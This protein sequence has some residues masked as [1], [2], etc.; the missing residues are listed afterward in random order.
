MSY[1]SLIFSL[2]V[3]LMFCPVLTNAQQLSPIDY[4]TNTP[5]DT[6]N[7][8]A[9]ILV[10]AD[11][12]TP[13]L[14]RGRPEP[15]ANNPATLVAITDITNQSNLSYQ[16]RIGNQNLITTN[17]RLTTTIPDQDRV[18]VTLNV[19]DSSNRVLAR[20]T[21]YINV[22]DPLIVFYEYNPL[23]AQSRTA[24]IDDYTLIGDEA[25][26]FAEPYFTGNKSSTVTNWTIGNTEVSTPIPFQITILKP[27][28]DLTAV[29]V[30]LSTYNT[31]RLSE[32]IEAGFNVNFGL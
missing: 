18:L 8:T 17:P 28:E 26:I 25:T 22:S 32:R 15:T 4:Q 14:Y 23:R 9:F 13:L 12:Y 6:V 29:P 3:T 27:T 30:S 16:W 21:E 7:N 11:T 31:N 19:L 20:T 2:G 24:I 10:E 5:V 1:R